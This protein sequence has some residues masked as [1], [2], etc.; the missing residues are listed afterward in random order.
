MHAVSCLNASVV[1]LVFVLSVS[2]VDGLEL[3]SNNV[4]DPRLQPDKRI[5]TETALGQ[6]SV[7]VAGLTEHAKLR[8]TTGD[9]E[10]GTLYRVELDAD[11]PRVLELRPF[12][13]NR[14]ESTETTYY[15]SLGVGVGLRASL[16]EKYEQNNWFIRL[17]ILTPTDVYIE[18]YSQTRTAD[19]VVEL[20]AGF[21]IPL[22]GEASDRDLRQRVT[23]PRVIQLGVSPVLFAGA[24]TINPQV[25][26]KVHAL[27]IG[28]YLERVK[29][30][31]Y[32]QETRRTPIASDWPVIRLIE[33]VTDE[34]LTEA[35]WLEL[36]T[37]VIAEPAQ[38]AARRQ[39][40]VADILRRGLTAMM[41]K[42]YP[43]IFEPVDLRADALGQEGVS[44]LCVARVSRPGMGPINANDP[45]DSDAMIENYIA[46]AIERVE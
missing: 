10:F 23:G 16:R 9:I 31:V 6:F 1:G 33:A 22:N 46:Y 21:E 19:S 30:V 44:D 39:A 7:G 13:F 8:S 43:L 20:F 40:I 32:G 38:R 28:A 14:I 36:Q 5:E 37:Q 15:E 17:S 34:Q 41:R 26:G 45:L 27:M 4:P 12:V 29:L 11:F 3:D 2:S 25:L 24:E 18:R 35:Q 42:P